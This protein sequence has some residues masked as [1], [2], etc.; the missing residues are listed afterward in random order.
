MQNRT[1]QVMGFAAAI[2][3]LLTACK[4]DKDSTTT[5]P[6][7][8]EVI[9][10]ISFSDL[11]KLSTSA[12]VTV[13]NDTKIRGIVISNAGKKNLDANTVILQDT[14]GGAGLVVSFGAAPTA[15]LGDL[16]EINVSKQ[17]LAQVN[18]EVILQGIAADSL[19]K[20]GTGTVTPKQTNAKDLTT[21]AAAWDGTLVTLPE[22]NFTGGNG[23]YSGTLQY[24]DS[25][26]T[27]A[28]VV[29]AGA[30]FEN[31]AYPLSV[32][33]L[34]GIVRVNGSTVQV[35]LRDTTDAPAKQGYF[36]VDDFSGADVGYYANPIYGY[37]I[38]PVYSGYPY[39]FIT[40]ATAKYNNWTSELGA[41]LS[42]YLWSPA[43]K[44][45]AHFGPMTAD[46]ADASFATVGRNYLTVLPVGA[47]LSGDLISGNGTLNGFSLY[48]DGSP[49]AY[50][51]YLKSITVVFACSKQQPAYQD[52]ITAGA[53]NSIQWN[54]SNTNYNTKILLTAGQIDY[55][56]GVNEVIDSSATFNDRGIWH[57]VKFEGDI[58]AKWL[59]IQTQVKSY[60]DPGLIHFRPA[61]IADYTSGTIT[62]S[63]GTYKFGNP[64]IIDKIILEFS[65]QPLWWQ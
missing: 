40:N 38:S 37:N 56:A 43:G 46:N 33:S 17:T 61:S 10:Q 50:A 25:T 39:Q 31:T 13:P 65:Q 59:A 34:T 3:L 16:V 58:N 8:P 26:G 36:F 2:A 18:G 62:T 27:T 21:N 48:F 6:P 44:N 64:I 20:V 60:S 4:K 30:S 51:K 32:A 55:Y 42:D 9:N 1:I 57:T 23:K 53:I 5:P 45:I 28:T 14:T 41:H 11:K 49:D 29:T 7:P 47:D 22:G 24:I 35:N 52:L 63:S 12:S 19:K 15:A 54:T